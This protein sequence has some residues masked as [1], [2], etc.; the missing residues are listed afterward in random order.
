M[1]PHPRIRIFIERF[2]VKIR[3]TMRILRK[4]RRY[5]VQDYADLIAVQGIDQ[6]LKVL[7]RSVTCRRCKI[8]R[9]LIPPRTVERMLCNTHQFHM[10]IFHFFKVFHN[11]VGKFT[12]IIK[13]VR[14]PV[15]MLHKRSDMALINCHRLFIRIFLRPFFHPH[16]VRPFQSGKVGDHRRGTRSELRII[17]ERIRLIKLSP[18]MRV[19]QKFIHISDF[20]F[21]NKRSI[22]SD[23]TQA[24]HITSFFI[25]S[26]KASEYMHGCRMRGPYTKINACLPV[27]HTRMRTQ[28]LVNIIVRTLSEHEHVRIGNKYTPLVLIAQQ[29]LRVLFSCLR[30][31]CGSRPLFCHPK[32]PL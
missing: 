32:Y 1:L 22:N 13:S 12:V 20:C 8:S 26:V 25:P 6:I 7:R 5:P 3:K 19:D 9:Y 17:C 4:M 15:G 27:L 10:G 2:S 28:L 16:R 18:V 24:L 30:F 11:T 29:I 14:S 21:R 31:L 23:I